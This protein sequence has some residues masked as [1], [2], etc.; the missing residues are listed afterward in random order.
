L[1]RRE[2]ISRSE[3][4]P[5]VGGYSRPGRHLAPRALFRQP[6]KTQ[7]RSNS[8]DTRRSY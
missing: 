4:F 2:D 6:G 1:S 5:A 3:L 7:L 8:A